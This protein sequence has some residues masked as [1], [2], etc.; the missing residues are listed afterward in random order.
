MSKSAVSTPP[1]LARHL[2][3]HGWDHL[4]PGPAGRPGHPVAGAARRAA[5]HGQV[6]AGRAPG[7]RP[8]PGLPP[9]QRLAAQLRRPGRHP[10]AGT[11]RL[12]PRFVSTPGSI[13][14]AEFVFFD[15]IS[16]CR[17]DL[18]NK[19]FPIVHERRVAGIDLHKLQHRWAAMNPPAPASVDDLAGSTTSTSAPRRSTPP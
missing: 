2:G 18:Q 7:R 6:A 1:R 12:A 16:R 5:R 10:H 17:A 4:D 8:R 15:E 9:L 11:G 14:D 19:L 3:I 13:W